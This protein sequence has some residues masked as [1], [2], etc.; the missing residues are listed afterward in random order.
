LILG[1]NYNQ[2]A[3]HAA[4]LKSLYVAAVS[5][6]P[7]LVLREH[8]VSVY[9]LYVLMASLFLFT[10]G[11]ELCMDFRDRDGDP[12]SFLDKMTEVSLGRVAFS[13]QATSLLLLLGATKT[14]KQALALAILGLLF[15]RSAR[16]W[17]SAQHYRRAIAT[18]KLQLLVG[19]YFLL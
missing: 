15:F 12:G 9:S 2:V 16:L 19:S 8:F 6:L 3:E 5:V 18:M 10:T 11:K 14:W 13:T 1:I 7:L 4:T 17:F